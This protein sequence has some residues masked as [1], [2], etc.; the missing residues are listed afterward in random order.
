MTQSTNL[1]HS[2]SVLVTEATDDNT[3]EWIGQVSLM[4]QE[5]GEIYIRITFNS[6]ADTYTGSARQSATN[7]HRLS[8][9]SI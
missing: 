9:D 8:I 4:P 5:N 3:T 6:E 2:Y 1:Q 7:D